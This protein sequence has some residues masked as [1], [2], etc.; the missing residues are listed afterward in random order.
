MYNIVHIKMKYCGLTLSFGFLLAFVSVLGALRP[1]DAR[2]LLLRP[3]PH[4]RPI[5]VCYDRKRENS[6]VPKTK[7]LTHY[8]MLTHELLKGRSF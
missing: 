4:V 8:T 3:R 6:I 7:K 5:S 1:L 2:R